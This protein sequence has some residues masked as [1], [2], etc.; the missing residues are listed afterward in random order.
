MLLGTGSSHPAAQAGS[1]AAT[2]HRTGQTP[3][4]QLTWHSTAGLCVRE[5]NAEEALT[6]SL[7]VIG[8]DEVLPV[9]VPAADWNVTG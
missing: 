3:S 2:P 7:L 1:P 4:P 6:D 5:A 9:A 8:I